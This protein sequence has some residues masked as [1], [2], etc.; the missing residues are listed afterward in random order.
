MTARP[1]RE[2]KEAAYQLGLPAGFFA[3]WFWY[4]ALNA[5]RLER[6]KQAWYLPW[7]QKRY[8]PRGVVEKLLRFSEDVIDCIEVISPNEEV[9]RLLTDAIIDF[10]SRHCRHDKTVGRS[11]WYILS[12][13]Q[14]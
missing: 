7:H 10:R 3:Y 2:S 5:E 8:I 9:Q 1:L 14:R 4:Y 6:S 11:W 12:K 13:R